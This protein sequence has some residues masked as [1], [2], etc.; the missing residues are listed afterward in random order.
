LMN[1]ALSG[2]AREAIEGHIVECSKCAAV[3][4]VV[5]ALKSQA[6]AQLAWEPDSTGRHAGSGP[7]A[8]GSVLPVQARHSPGSGQVPPAGLKDLDFKDLLQDASLIR[9]DLEQGLGSANTL[10]EPVRH[11]S[12]GHLDAAELAAFFYGEMIGEAAAAAAGHLAMCSDCATAISLYCDSHDAAQAG[13]HSTSAP[14]KMSDESW[15][16][17]K[18]WEENCL[19][20]PRAESETPSREMLERFLQILRDHREEID[21]I[22]TSSPFNH[23]VGTA[24][25]QIVP[26]VVLDS[27]GSFRGVEPFHR[28]SRPRG[29]EALQ[30]IAQPY[31]FH[32]LPIHALIGTERQYP[33]VISARINR[34]I[35]EL[36]YGSAQTGLV[37]PLG[38]FIVEN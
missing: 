35:A 5:R 32:N 14:L 28:V 31:R 8:S 11:G 15:K 25:P 30:Y 34:D 2:A 19:A 23:A 21:R 3:A 17:I 16:L 7:V 38:Y 29:L 12:P 26:V 37:R 4:A 33:M 24:M 18:Q 20:E 22:A 10:S 9:P 13:D 36:D 1:G 6:H 27:A